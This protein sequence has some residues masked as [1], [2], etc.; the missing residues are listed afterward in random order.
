[1]TIPYISADDMRGGLDFAG[2]IEA[3]RTEH[4]NESPE[5]ERTLMTQ[6]MSEASDRSYVVACLDT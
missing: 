1:M 6:E 5:M 4:L 2:L 3:L